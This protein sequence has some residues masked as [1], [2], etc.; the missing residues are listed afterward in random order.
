MKTGR[1]RLRFVPA[2]ASPIGHRLLQQM[3]RELVLAQSSDWPFI[4][5]MDTA[6]YYAEQRVRDHIHRF[7]LLDDALQGAALDVEELQRI[8]EQDAIFPRLDLEQF[9][10]QRRRG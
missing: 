4:I 2:A 1:K 10:R 9:R 3:A 7:F 5:T 6:T 8:E